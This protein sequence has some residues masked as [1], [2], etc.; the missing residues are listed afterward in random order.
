MP[1]SPAVPPITTPAAFPGVSDAE[2]DTELAGL[3]AGP[4]ALATDVEVAD[5]IATAIAAKVDKSTLDAN[6]LLGAT[7]DNT[8]IAFPV[9]PSRVVGRK[10]SGDID[11]MTTAEVAALFGAPDGTK[12]LADDGTLK[13]AGGASHSLYELGLMR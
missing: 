8:P 6:T 9:A 2:L 7:A 1:P 3:I 10:A 4:N 11:D 12:F 13:T 5:A